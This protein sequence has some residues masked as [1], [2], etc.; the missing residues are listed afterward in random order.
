[1]KRIK[2][3]ELNFLSNYFEMTLLGISSFIISTIFTLIFIKEKIIPNR[4]SNDHIKGSQKI[5]NSNIKRIGGLPIILSIISM[6]VIYEFF[7][8]LNVKYDLLIIYIYCNIIFFVGFTEDLVK[9]IKPR[10]RL[11]ALFLITFLWLINYSESIQNTNIDFVDNIIKFEAFAIILTIIC[12]ISTLNATNMMDGAN[13]LLTIFVIIVNVIL[14]FYASHSKDL[15]LINFLLILIGT[16]LGFLVFNWPKG[17]IFLGDGGSYFLGS[18]L[19]TVLIYMSNEPNNFNMLN[20]LIIMIYPVWELTFTVF[21]RIYFSSDV[22]Q[23]DNLHL[24]TILHANIKKINLEKK[25]NVNNNALTGLIINIIALSPSIIFLI[26]KFDTNLEDNE[27]ISFFII[28]FSM[29]TIF[30]LSLIKMNKN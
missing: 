27:S 30:Y 29:Y 16:L 24:H 13:G 14:L 22:T 26:Y 8:K 7:F 10:Y 19:S 15:F 11:L 20:A 21:R 6:L 18:I 23:P 2:E 9:D 25:C 17:R 1:M 12:I 5:H 3:L 4:Y 28:I